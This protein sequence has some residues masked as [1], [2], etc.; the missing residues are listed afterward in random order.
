VNTSNAF[1]GSNGAALHQVS[2]DGERLIL[3]EPHITKRLF[4]R[5]DESRVEKRLV[6]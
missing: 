5:L 6:V 3:S 2:K 4:I 1:G